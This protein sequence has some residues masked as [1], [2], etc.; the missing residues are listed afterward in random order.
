M[1]KSAK[2]ATPPEVVSSRCSKIE[3]KTR[4]PTWAHPGGAVGLAGA[5]QA[6]ENGLGDP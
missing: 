2:K 4:Q 6:L 5:A 1:A 3:E